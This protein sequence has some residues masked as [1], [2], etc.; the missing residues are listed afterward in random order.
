MNMPTGN[1]K[2]LIMLIVCVFSLTLFGTAL[3]AKGSNSKLF[4]YN[5]EGKLNTPDKQKLNLQ[6]RYV[7]NT[8]LVKIANN[9]FKAYDVNIFNNRTIEFSINPTENKS[10]KLLFKG[11][12]IDNWIMGGT[13][14]SDSQENGYWFVKVPDRHTVSTVN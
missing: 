2:L 1:L 11:N 12:I 9:N 14:T 6:I 7:D 8:F 5:L 10:T 4:T 13:V 3:F